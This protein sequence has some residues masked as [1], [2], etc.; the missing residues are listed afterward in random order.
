MTEPSSPRP[1]PGPP[2]PAAPAPSPTGFVPAEQERSTA[3]RF[4]ELEQRP[5]AEHVA[6]F[7][8]E[9]GRLQ[10]ELGTIDQL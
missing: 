3:D 2:R 5:V 10:R 6:V 4:A 8:A 7:E 1:V 9:H